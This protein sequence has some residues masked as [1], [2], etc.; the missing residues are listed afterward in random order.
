MKVYCVQYITAV[1]YSTVQCSTVQ[2]STVQCSAAPQE[3][4]TPERAPPDAFNFGISNVVCNVLQALW[5]V[6]LTKE[7][8][9]PREAGRSPGIEAVN[10]VRGGQGGGGWRQ[11]GGRQYHV[12]M[13]ERWDEV[14]WM[15]W[16]KCS[17]STKAGGCLWPTRAQQKLFAKPLLNKQITLFLPWPSP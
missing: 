13:T 2:C 9:K 12:G 5:P 7:I 17:G 3:M 4:C 1:Q 10:T 15:K 8:E 14:K 16:M 6:S 11:F